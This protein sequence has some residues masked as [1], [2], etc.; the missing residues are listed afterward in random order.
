M[1]RRFLTK[2]AI[3][4]DSYLD[5]AINFCYTLI[6]T[7]EVYSKDRGQI[8]I[9]KKREIN[10]RKSKASPNALTLVFT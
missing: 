4:N 2:C 10:Q 7:L 3:C 1:L 9:R 5:S 6:R 8:H